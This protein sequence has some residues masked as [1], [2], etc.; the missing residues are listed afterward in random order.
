[1][2]PDQ[3][4]DLAFLILKLIKKLLF[5][6]LRKFLTLNGFK[7]NFEGSYEMDNQVY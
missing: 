7:K 4:L 3:G 2:V 1:M 6:A 5:T